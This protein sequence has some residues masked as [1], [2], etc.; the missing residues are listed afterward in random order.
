MAAAL[1]FFVVKDATD[2]LSAGSKGAGLG[3]AMYG[4]YDLTNYSTLTNYPLSFA[5]TDIVWGSLLF[6]TTAGLATLI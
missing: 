1:W 6:G 4:L 3:L 5:L 2:W